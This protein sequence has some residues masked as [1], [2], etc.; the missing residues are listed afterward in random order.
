M[1]DF[2][3]PAVLVSLASGC[4]ALGYLIINKMQLRLFVLIGSAFYI[5]YYATAAAEPLYG[6]IYTT[7]GLTTA[8]LIG[9]IILTMGRFRIALPRAHA[10]IYDRF[11]IVN[12]GDF[13]QVMKHAT[14][15]TLDQDT[16]VTHE[17]DTVTH[18]VYVIKGAINVTKT[19]A[20]FTMPAGVFIGEV[21]YL[22]DRPSAATSTVLAG[23]E[24]VRWDLNDMRRT[25]ARN[26]R[27]K[28][29]MD[30][31]LGHDLAQKVTHAVAHPASPVVPA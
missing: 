23:A 8:N 3:T 14:R 11:N 17:G 10:D 2:F 19:G 4:Y 31:I 25:S 27:F 16:V 20:Q 9:M 18:L 30:A 12:P 1:F 26:P 15:T 22:L 5:A 6:A 29:A 7:I 21:A 28:L 24:I 13:R